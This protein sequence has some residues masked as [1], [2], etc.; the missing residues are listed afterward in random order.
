VSDVS[1]CVVR[2]PHIARFSFDEQ[3]LVTIKN[4]T[5][6][7]PSF[8]VVWRMEDNA[9]TPVHGSKLSNKKVLSATMS[10][11]GMFLGIGCADGKSKIINMRWW[12]IEYD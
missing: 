5:K 11:E 4:S 3:H 10:D 7:G 2:V 1:I 8:I 6:G 9:V 12:I